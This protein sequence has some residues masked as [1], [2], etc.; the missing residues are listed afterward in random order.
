MK[1]IAYALLVGFLTLSAPAFAAKHECKAAMECCK[2]DC[3]K[4]SKCGEKCK[5]K[6][7]KSCCTST[8]DIKK[9]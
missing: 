4:E 1:R 6:C 7:G 9:S 5:A 8:C 3:C 2:T